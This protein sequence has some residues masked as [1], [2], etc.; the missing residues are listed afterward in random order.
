MQFVEGAQNEMHAAGA[1]AG[2]R[3]N[4]EPAVEGGQL[5]V[6]LQVHYPHETFLQPEMIHVSLLRETSGYRFSAN[7][8]PF[9]KVV[10]TPQEVVDLFFDALLAQNA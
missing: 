1:G 10:S 9:G 4:E 3:V 7:M 6:D 2:L 5:S 8:T